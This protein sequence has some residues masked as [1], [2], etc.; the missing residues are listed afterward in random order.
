ML[1]PGEPEEE[2][3]VLGHVGQA[4]TRRASVGAAGRQT[5][6]AGRSAEHRDVSPASTGRRP[7]MVSSVVVLPAPFGPSSATTS[8][9]SHLQVDPC[10]T[11][12]PS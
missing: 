4:P 7:E 12:T 6:G 8:P 9:A 5:A 2:R 11:A 10:T 1:A 3:A